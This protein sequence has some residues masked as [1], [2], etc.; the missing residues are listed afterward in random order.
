M[1]ARRSVVL[2]GAILAACFMG[3]AFV[4]APH[5]A[6]Q[7]TQITGTLPPSALSVVAMVTPTVAHAAEGSE[8]IPAL[9]AVGAGFAIGLAAIGS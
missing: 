5:R 4:A 8:W 6:P 7:A 1:V 9:S 2:T 3:T